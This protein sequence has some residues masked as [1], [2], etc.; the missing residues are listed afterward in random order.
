MAEAAGEAGG[1]EESGTGADDRDHSSNGSPRGAFE[2]E[3][4]AHPLLEGVALAVDLVGE[5]AHVGSV[6]VHGEHIGAHA[7][8]IEREDPLHAG[9]TREC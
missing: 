5:P 3:R 2:G 9:T 8:E 4:R 7:V 1:G 6:G